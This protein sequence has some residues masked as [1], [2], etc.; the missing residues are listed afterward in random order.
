MTETVGQYYFGKKTGSWKT[1]D[2]NG[3]LVKEEFYINGKLT[4]TKSY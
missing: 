3:K 4:E 2:Q 1:Y